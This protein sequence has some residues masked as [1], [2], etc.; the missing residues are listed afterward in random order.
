MKITA[1]RIKSR[2]TARALIAFFCA[3][4]I[5]VSLPGAPPPTKIG[6]FVSPYWVLDQNGNRTWDGPPT[7]GLYYWS[8]G[9][10]NEVPVYGDWNGDGRT[11]MGV[12]LNG[13]WMLDYDGNGILDGNDKIVY[14]GG[15][16]YTPVVGDWNG[17]GTTKIGAYRDGVWLIDYNGNFA[18]DGPNTDKLVFFGGPSYTPVVGDWNGS[19]TTKIGAY[20]N[21]AWVLDYNGNWAWDDPNSGG[22]DKLVSWSWH[23][24]ETP[25]VGNWNGLGN[26]NGLGLTTKIGVYYEGAWMV[27]YNGN[28]VWDGPTVDKLPYFGGPGYTPKVGDWNGSGT[29]KIAA[30]IGGAW[31]IDVNGN[32]N[33]D[34]GAGGPNDDVLTSFGGQGQTPVVGGWPLTIRGNAT[35]SGYPLLGATMNLGGS[36]SDVATTDNSGNYSF[37]VTAGG[38]YTVTASEGGL[39]FTP[40]SLSWNNLS[41]NQTADFT[42]V[43]ADY[44][45]GSGPVSI[46]N[47]FTAPDPV[48]ICD[49]ISGDWD[50]AV[51]SNA[52][53][54]RLAQTD[55]LINGQ[56]LYYTPSQSC[57]SNNPYCCGIVTYGVMGS[58]DSS[59]RSYSLSATNP[60]LYPSDYCGYQVLQSV[61]STVT[62]SGRAC[63]AGSAQ[64]TSYGA[65]NIRAPLNKRLPGTMPRPV[66]VNPMSPSASERPTAIETVPPAAKAPRHPDAQSSSVWTTISPRFLVQYSS[67]IPVDHVGGPT[68]CLIPDPIADYVLGAITYKGDA[69]RGTYRTTQS[70]LVVPDTRKTTPLFA[71]AGPTRSYGVPSSPANGVNANLSSTP[72]GDLWT[73]PYS[74]ADE[75]EK[76]FDCYR[77]HN[78]GEALNST[79]Q[80]VGVGWGNPITQVNLNGYASDPLE[81]SLNGVFAVRWNLTVTLDTTDPQNPKASVSSGTANCYP[82]H[83]VKVNGVNI[84]DQ[85]VTSNDFGHIANCL[86][87]LGSPIA[88]SNPKGV[89]AH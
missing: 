51:G 29:T 70:L 65:S 42:A 71:R 72:L 85:E 10:S 87:S 32:Y 54:W 49:D 27:D 21:G 20:L 35:A 79:M 56:M 64:W 68:P 1:C 80:G 55:T 69:Y 46:P 26:G 60:S 66:R 89:P 57:G 61:T 78:K 47:S 34:P 19:G 73:D 44:P 33:W 28:F 11:K 25:M 13:T 48:L 45:A 50:E 82:E 88:P 62:L 41:V 22:A 9:D 77:W 15:P 14:L 3:L 2:R 59:T 6:A 7:D 4:S 36:R 24:G 43:P 53:G 67:Y 63:G 40:F 23:S 52:Y 81:S 86:R 75:D 17:S 83:I 74:G 12:Y 30:Y 16:G 58:Y 31:Y 5:S 39:A 38:N 18:W 76:R 84:F 8:T 37:G